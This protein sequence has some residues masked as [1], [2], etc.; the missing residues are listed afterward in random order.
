MLYDV[1]CYMYLYYCIYIYIYIRIIVPYILPDNMPETML[2]QCVRVGI[3]RRFCAGPPSKSNTSKHMYMCRSTSKISAFDWASSH[4]QSVIVIVRI[5]HGPLQICQLLTYCSCVEKI[6]TV[7]RK[8]PVKR[9]ETNPWGWGKWI[10]RLPGTWPPGPWG[11]R[12]RMQGT[13]DAMN[14]RQ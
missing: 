6:C 3:T 2:E 4:L 14:Q 1:K 5:C 12:P 10:L 13:P 11:L 9:C 8:E 7:C